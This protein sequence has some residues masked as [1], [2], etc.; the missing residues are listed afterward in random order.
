MDSINKKVA[1]IDFDSLQ[2]IADFY[3]SKTYFK[4]YPKSDEKFN[5]FHL[6]VNE[7]SLTLNDSISLNNQSKEQIHQKIWNYMAENTSEKPGRLYLN[8]NRN[9]TF[10]RFLDYYIFFKTKPI[11]KGKTSNTIFIFNTKDIRK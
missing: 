1:F 2:I 10:N 11:P 7:N 3:L 5:K 9:I 4:K 6:T 8:F